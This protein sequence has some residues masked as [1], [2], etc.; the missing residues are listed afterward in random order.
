MKDKMDTI[1]RACLCLLALCPVLALTS[2][3]DDDD[4]VLP[5]WQGIA[6]TYTG[7]TSA[8][9]SYSPL[10]IVYEDETFIIAVNSDGTASLTLVSQKWN[11]AV[12]KAKVTAG[13]GLYIIEGDA[14]ADLV[15]HD[16]SGDLTYQGSAKATVS[17]DG[18]QCECVFDLPGLMNGT[19]VTFSTG[20]LPDDY[21]TFDE[22]YGG[23]T[24]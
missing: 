12:A 8:V 23:F 11:V 17:T 14:E 6:G 1:R 5:A 7:F 3:D 4:E 15:M 13:D 9:F 22:A 18:K 2:C 19:V 20:D 24:N 10:P 21:I 16:D